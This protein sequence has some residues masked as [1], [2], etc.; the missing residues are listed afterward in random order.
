MGSKVQLNTCISSENTTKLLL[1]YCVCNISKE[2][3]MAANNDLIT[4]FPFLQLVI[5]RTCMICLE[6]FNLRDYSENGTKRAITFIQG[7][8]GHP[9]HMRCFLDWIIHAEQEYDVACQ[10]LIDTVVLPNNMSGQEA[11]NLFQERL[12]NLRHVNPIC[13]TCATPLVVNEY[14]HLTAMAPPPPHLIPSAQHLPLAP[15]DIPMD[16]HVTLPNYRSGCCNYP[17]LPREWFVITQ[18]CRHTLHTRC[19]LNLLMGNM[20]WRNVRRLL[21]PDNIVRCPT[22]DVVVEEVHPNC[23]RAYD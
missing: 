22:C 7:C 1:C 23:V 3:Q 15:Y 6:N 16:L 21:N 4:R 8:H 13:S 9:A 2:D 17:H 10:H 12:S 20:S 14:I 5:G 18:P 19:Y 11:A